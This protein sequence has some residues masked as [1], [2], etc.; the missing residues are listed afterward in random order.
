M[1]NTS[2]EEGTKFQAALSHLTTV[3]GQIKILLYLQSGAFFDSQINKKWSMLKLAERLECHELVVGLRGPGV[4][5]DGLA[6][7]DH[8]KLDPLVLDDLEVD[9]ALQVADVDPAGP[10]LDGVVRSQ[11]LG[12]EPREVVDSD[13]VLLAGYR[14]QDVLT[15]ENL[16]LLEA[17]SGNQ[18][19]NLA[20][21]RNTSW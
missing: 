6:Q 13:A 11:D 18:L 2:K 21:K 15:L 17:A 10:T 9:G 4:D 3:T 14:D 20:L 12:L 8:Q 16:H 7:R 1:A 5:L 19:V